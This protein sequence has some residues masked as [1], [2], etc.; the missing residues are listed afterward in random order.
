ATASAWLMLRKG[1]K[2]HGTLSSSTTRTAARACAAAT[3]MPATPSAIWLILLRS[4]SKVP[5]SSIGARHAPLVAVLARP[6]SLSASAAAATRGIEPLE[7]R[8]HVLDDR[9]GGARAAGEAVHQVV[10][11]PLPAGAVFREPDELLQLLVG[12]PEE[13][14]RLH[15]ACS[16]GE[17]DLDA[18]APRQLDQPA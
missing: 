6:R 2:E 4:M 1:A 15:V 13:R 9:A 18:G 3:S 5:P 14:D 8:A 10:G 16:A 17:L 12:S 7:E 11:H